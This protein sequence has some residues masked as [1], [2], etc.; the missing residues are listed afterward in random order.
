MAVSSSFHLQPLTF[1]DPVYSL[2]NIFKAYEVHFQP[3]QNEDYWSTYIGPN[4]MLDP[5]M[6]HNKSEMDQSLPNKP[7]N[8]LFAEV[9]IIIEATAQINSEILFYV[10]LVTSVY[11]LGCSLLF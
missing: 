10:T 11:R 9:S 7:K 3:V 1:V 6:R 2:Q 4:L 8:V 5:H